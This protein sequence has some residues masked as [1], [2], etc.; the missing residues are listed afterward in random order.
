MDRRGDEGRRSGTGRGRAGRDA[1]V[2]RED[3]RRR[4]PP[5]ESLSGPRRGGS[6]AAARRGRAP[7]PR[8]TREGNKKGRSGRDAPCASSHAMVSATTRGTPPHPSLHASRRGAPK[9]GIV[10]GSGG[11]RE[12]T[13]RARASVP[14]RLRREKRFTSGETGKDRSRFGRGRAEKTRSRKARRA[15]S[16]RHQ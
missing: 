5:L 3:A 4:R 11:V 16:F 2:R 1:R 12:G 14:N 8:R 13:A 7:A 9:I 10:G 15:P 6:T